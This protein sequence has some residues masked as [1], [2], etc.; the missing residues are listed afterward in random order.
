VTELWRDAAFPQQDDYDG[1]FI[2]GGP[3]NVHE[4]EEYPWLAAEQQ[5]IARTVTWHKPTLGIC[6]GAQ[7]LAVVLGGQVTEML[8]K[9]I[10]W[11]PVDLTPAGRQ[12]HLFR[13]F[14]DRFPAL[15]WHGDSFSTPPGAI[16][17]ARSDACEQQAFVYENYVVGMQFHLESNQRSIAELILN[18]GED[19]GCG[20]SIQ[21][22][23]AIE[24]DAAALTKGNRLLFGL[25]E[26]LASGCP[27]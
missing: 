1:L 2:L 23:Y 27:P 18:C 24:Q 25:L 9:E 4:T 6:L 10:G 5:F 11:F 19:L 16:H 26:K 12:S 14:P 15:H 17:I 13:D 21:D 7:L 8:D 22:P 20:E 3:M